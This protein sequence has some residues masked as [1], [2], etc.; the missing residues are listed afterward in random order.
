MG[1]VG[2]VVVCTRPD[3]GL[4][5]GEEYTI[6]RH[7]VGTS[8]ITVKDSSG[9]VFGSGGNFATIDMSRFTFS[10]QELLHPSGDK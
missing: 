6:I 9:R 7:D 8:F 4:V 2:Q 5:E 1:I 3:H 10:T